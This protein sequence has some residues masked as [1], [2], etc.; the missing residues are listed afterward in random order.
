[1]TAD[2][3]FNPLEVPQYYQWVFMGRQGFFFGGG[4]FWGHKYP[5]AL[6]EVLLT[7]WQM[8]VSASK[9]SLLARDV[10]NP[11]YVME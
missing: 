8:H 11:E 4:R 10:W 7:L 3:V 2:R 9:A 1:M 5:V 6:V